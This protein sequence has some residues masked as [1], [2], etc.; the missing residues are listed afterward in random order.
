MHVEDTEGSSKDRLQTYWGHANFNLKNGLSNQ[1][2]G[3]VH[4]Q[5]KHLQ[6][7]DFRYVIDVENTSLQVEAGMVR[8]FMAQKNNTRGRQLIFEEQRTLW[9]ELD[10]FSYECECDGCLFSNRL[11]LP[12]SVV[13]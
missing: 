4:V 5:F 6:H 8:I 13:R 3:D 10:R 2:N 12:L 11:A 9:F 7:K 1:P